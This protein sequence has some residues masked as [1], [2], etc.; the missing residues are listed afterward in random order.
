MLASIEV[1]TEGI[2]HVQRSTQ[3]FIGEKCLGKG[4]LYVT[5][6]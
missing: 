5:E 2:H 6:E 1:P 3:A 4:A